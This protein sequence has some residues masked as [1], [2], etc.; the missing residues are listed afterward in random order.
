MRARLSSIYWVPM[1]TAVGQ[2]EPARSFHAAYED[3]NILGARK[4]SFSRAV[5]VQP[6]EP[7]SDYSGGLFDQRPHG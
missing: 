5:A 4:Q 1:M 6:S 2:I 7:L 3:M